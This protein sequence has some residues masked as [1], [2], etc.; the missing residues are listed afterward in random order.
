[1]SFFGADSAAAAAAVETDPDIVGL[2]GKLIVRPVAQKGL[3]RRRSLNL[4]KH[5]HI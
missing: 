3:Y 5:M 1:M 4:S 2:P